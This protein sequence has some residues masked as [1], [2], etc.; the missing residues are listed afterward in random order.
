M[1]QITIDESG[2]HEPAVA[3][4][5]ARAYAH[6]AGS[7]GIAPQDYERFCEAAELAHGAVD[8][9]LVAAGARGNRRAARLRKRQLVSAAMVA[10]GVPQWARALWAIG[11]LFA[12][13]WSVVI[14]AILWVVEQVT[15]GE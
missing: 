12:P 14:Q 10:N 13:Q 11:M 5:H 8:K 2:Q 6:A 9:T 15:E 1:S 4:R 3:A 7:D